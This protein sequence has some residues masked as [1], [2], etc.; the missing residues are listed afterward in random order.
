MRSPNVLTYAVAYF[1]LCVISLWGIGGV[2]VAPV[3]AQS[4][5]AGTATSSASSASSTPQEDALDALLKQL[6][7]TSS[8]PEYLLNAKPPT[9]ADIPE[10]PDEF[11]KAPLNV[12]LDPEYPAAFQ[13]VMA[14]VD[15]Y[16][17]DMDRSTIT[18]SLNGKVL[19]TG[20]G[21]KTFRF[22][23]G[24]N[25]S[26][27]TLT[28]SVSFNGVESTKNLSITPAT[29]DLLWQSDSYVPPFYKGKALFSHQSGIKV[30]A[31][32]NIFT[33]DG[34]LIP[35]SKLIYRWK[36]DKEF[37]AAVS[38]VGKN[39]VTFRDNI[40]VNEKQISVEVSTADAS[41]K[42]VGQIF[43]RS[44]GTAPIVYQDT[45]LTGISYERALPSSLNLADSEMKLVIEPYFF[46]V[47]SRDSNSLY[48]S[49]SLNGKNVTDV[50]RSSIVFKVPEAEKG[51]AQI[52]AELRQ[53]TRVF[54][55][56][57]AGLIIN[58][59]SPGS[60]SQSLF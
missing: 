47:K 25:G 3:S 54:Q 37:V 52:N 56:N 46:S 59:V 42:T 7:A 1:C 8:I 12:T 41:V 19:Q 49:W 2:A 18:W 36:L 44:V 20:I 40:P 6:T 4:S 57:A 14:S 48:Y 53:P 60:A 45:P 22:K 34:V 58:F 33:K 43:L 50:T 13:D 31:T 51:S 39:I 55:T 11:K 27:T 26:Y 16:S 15:S 30:V 35:T 17:A 5:S 29:V 21:A 28:V 24:R 9:E 10:L 32:P 38:G 23:A